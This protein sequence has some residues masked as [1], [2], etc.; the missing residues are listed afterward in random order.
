MTIKH[1]K[2]FLEVYKEMNIT[3]AAEKLHLVQ[4]AVTR[5]IKELE[6]YYGVCLFERINHRLSLTEAGNELY[7][8]AIH[9]TESFDLVEKK[10]MDWDS[11]GSLRIGATI[12]LGTV[13]LPTVLP[14]FSNLHRDLK[15]KTIVANSASLQD[16]LENNTL[17]MALIE[18]EVFN[19]HFCRIPFQHDELK[20]IFSP[21]HELTGSSIITLSDLTRFPFLMRDKGSVGRDTIEHIFAARDLNIDLAMESSST[22]AIVH[23]VHAGLGI[24]I[25]PNGLVKHDIESGYVMTGDIADADFSRVL[26]VVYHKN[27]YLT[28][29]A[30]DFISICQHYS[31][32]PL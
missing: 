30:Q 22:Q 3:R 15:I 5:A 7:S 11:L 19:D 13:F 16:A 8:Y 32:L 31:K 4:P 12:T 2:I 10:L 14:L 27:K 9:I 17:D 18:G 21:Q 25:L 29:S 24:A 26:Y 1:L 28:K 6:S 23:A 20:L